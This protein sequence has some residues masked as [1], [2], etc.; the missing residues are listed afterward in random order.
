M[1]IDRKERSTLGDE[2]DRASR[3][4]D[5]LPDVTK[6]KA[7]TL[8]A[9][10]PVIE[11]TQ[12]YIVQTLRQRD[13][14]DTIFLEYIGN[15]GSIRLAL[16]PIVADAIARQRDALTG[17]IRSKTAKANAADRKARGIEPGFKKK[18]G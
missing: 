3:A 14:G 6:T 18:K 1:A 8:R 5:G 11:N 10:S 12:T 16:P 4:L 13:A 17:K 9:K 7:T 15:D 2:F